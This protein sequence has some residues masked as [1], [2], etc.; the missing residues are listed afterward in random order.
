M[1][2]K[3]FNAGIIAR[4]QGKSFLDNPFLKTENLPAQTGQSVESWNEKAQ[5]WRDGWEC[6]NLLRSE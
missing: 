4:S 1:T 6:E 2:N 3:V 5:A